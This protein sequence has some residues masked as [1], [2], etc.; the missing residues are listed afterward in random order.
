MPRTFSDHHSLNLV[1][2]RCIFYSA[3]KLS[4]AVA[5]YLSPALCSLA[6]GCLIP[7]TSSL[8]LQIDSCCLQDTK[9]VCEANNR[10]DMKQTLNPE[11]HDTL[12]RWGWPEQLPYCFIQTKELNPPFT[13]AWQ[14]RKR[15]QLLS[16]TEKEGK[17]GSEGEHIFFL[18]KKLIYYDAHRDL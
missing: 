17:S 1:L 8:L 16:D 15:K 11:Q 10:C 5:F 12:V 18:V 13:S 7:I 2:T 9:T 3:I 6:N 4:H 14:S